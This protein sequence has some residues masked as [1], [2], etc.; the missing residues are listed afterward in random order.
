MDPDAVIPGVGRVADL[1]V[2]LRGGL[3]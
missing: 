1:L 3:S 2:A